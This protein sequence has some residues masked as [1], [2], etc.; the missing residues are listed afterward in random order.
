[1]KGKTVIVGSASKPG[2]YAQKAAAMLAERAFEFVPLGIQEGEV[3]GREIL[4][5]ND[6]PKIEEVDTITLYI[7]PT[8]QKAHYQY[9]LSLNPKRIVF[10]PG[11]ENQ[12]F[13]QMAEKAGIE[14]Q[15]AC[16]LVMLSVGNY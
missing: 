4:D 14:C 13:K 5:I 11:T 6:E 3:L 12:E 15:E 9:F 1:M 10:N 2:R 16:T 7:N 8:R